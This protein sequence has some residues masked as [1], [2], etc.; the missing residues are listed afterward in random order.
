M[1]LER[2][3]HRGPACAAWIGLASLFLI[4]PPPGLDVADNRLTA[5]ANVNALD[6]DCLPRLGARAH[7][8]ESYLGMVSTW[9]RRLA[10]IIVAW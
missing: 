9:F 2:A 5:V 4:A 7:S 8:A 6:P 3:V 10:I 1:R